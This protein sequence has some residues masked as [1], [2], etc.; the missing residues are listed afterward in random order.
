MSDSPR[1]FTVRR[2]TVPQHGGM[3][4]VAVL[5]I[6]A[7]LSVMTIGLSATVRQQI[8]AVSVQRDGVTGQALGE[9]AIALALQQ[10]HAMPERPR[11]IASV[12]VSYAGVEIAVEARPLGGL[13]SLNGAPRELL[14]A[15]FQSAGGLSAGPAQ[16][17]ADA[18]VQWRDGQPELDLNADPSARQ[19]RT[20]EAVEDLLLVPGIDYPLYARV[21]PLLSADLGG[22]ARVNPQAAPAEVLQVL[23]QGNTGAVARYLG[24]RAN[25]QMTADSS[26]FNPAFIDNAVGDLYRLQADVPLDAGK[27]LRLARDVAIHST[28]APWR[29]LRTE[30]RIVAASP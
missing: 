25:R 24:Q 9:A 20:F 6:V 22:A 17:L 19:A 7:A 21:A 13:I 10:L 30:R 5:W 8:R 3:A 27:I 14:A 11:G 1:L 2:A 29:I 4:L 28:L 23:A 18:A 12:P 26:V 15:V 16:A